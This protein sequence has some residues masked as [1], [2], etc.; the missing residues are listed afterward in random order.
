MEKDSRLEMSV[1]SLYMLPGGMLE[2]DKGVITYRVDSGKKVKIPVIMTLVETSDGNIL[3]DTGLNPDGLFDPLGAWGERAAKIVSKFDPEDDVRYR[4]KEL[5]L[6]TDDIRYVVNSHLH[7]DHTGGNRFFTK[8]KFI[9]QKAEYRFAHYPDDFAAA[10][11]LKDHF[12]RPLDYQLI[13]G[14]RELL[15]GVS[16]VTTYGHTPGSQSMVVSLPESGTVILPGD[17]I[18][19]EENIEKN[20]PAGNC[21]DP[22]QAMLS[23]HRLIHIAKRENGELFITHDPNAWKKLKPSPQCYH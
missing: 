21:W 12:D 11:Y 17:A 5:G 15:P 9:V 10:A 7:Y 4:L 6:K 1:K 22:G 13:E 23:M 8:S 16:L 18:Y 20:I 14:D 3:F 2:L 19:C